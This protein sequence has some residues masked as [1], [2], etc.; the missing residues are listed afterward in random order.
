MRYFLFCLFTV[1]SD[2]AFSQSIHSNLLTYVDNKGQTLP[3]KTLYDWQIKRGQILDSMVSLFGKF[4]GDPSRLPFD[5]KVPELPSF[6]T[7]IKDSLVTR[8]YTRYNIQ[9]TVAKKEHVTAY[10]YIPIEEKKGKKYPAIIAC[11]PTGDLGKKI[12]DG[13]H[14]VTEV[15]ERN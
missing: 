10:L 2:F 8:F 12:V 11:Q 6:N 1:F 4:P 7:I 5:A 3:V 15:M 13:A 14:T 9:F